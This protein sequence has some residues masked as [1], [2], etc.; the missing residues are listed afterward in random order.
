[1]WKCKVVQP[2]W[3]TEWWFLQ[4]LNVELPYNPAIPLL[5]LYPKE[6]K[7]GTQRHICTLM[8]I[9]ASFTTAKK[10]EQPQMFTDGWM[11]K[12]NVVP[13]CNGILFS[14]ERKEILTHTATWIHLEDIMLNETSQ[15]QKAKYCMIPLTWGTQSSQIHRDRGWNGGF[16][17]L[18]VGEGESVFNGDRVSVWGDETALEM[19][20]S[21]GCTT[22]WMYLVL[23]NCIL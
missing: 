14:L 11:D 15:Q 16:Q 8:F 22:M 5:S 12:Q 21:D 23:L 6:L 1:M 10:W 13:T 19:D 20:G 7:A 2:L 3:K 9:A 18:G 4:K 17:G